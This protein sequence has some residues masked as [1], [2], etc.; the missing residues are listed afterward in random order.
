[1]SIKNSGK[2]NLEIIYAYYQELID[3]ELQDDLDD[4]KDAFE[5]DGW[6]VE[7]YKK[8]DY[9]GFIFTRNN[10]NVKDFEGV[11]NSDAFE[12]LG[13]GEFELTKKGSTYTIEW[14][15]NAAEDVEEEGVSSADLSD[16]GGFMEVVLELP[17]PAI[18]ENATNV[19]KDGKKLTWNLIAEDDIEVTFKLSNAGVIVA[20]IVI[21][22]ALLAG[23]A[24]VVILLVLKKKKPADSKAAPAAV[25][26]AP[27]SSPEPSSPI[28]F[29][30]PVAPVTAPVPEAAAPVA[31]V[32]EAPAVAPAPAA[33]VVEAPI[34]APAPEV[35]V[36][37][38]EP[39]AP[40][41]E[42]PVAAPAPEVPAAPAAPVTE[43]PVAAPAPEVPVAPAAP[44]DGTWTCP[45]CGNTGITS[46]FCSGC[47]TER[48]LQ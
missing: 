15:T 10:V 9:K 28:D 45:S 6:T 17:S 37:V 1:M 30:A 48:P 33:P 43:T 39:A 40:V 18:E 19:S 23:A 38:P 8:N 20:V 34:V 46:R 5:D 11:F 14:D 47:G 26:A 12:K 35:P 44:A 31:P 3:E 42:T 24:V 2:A 7:K 21:I 29:S 36:A 4:L 13:L 32:S 41:A 27:V 22:F 25:P 16:Y